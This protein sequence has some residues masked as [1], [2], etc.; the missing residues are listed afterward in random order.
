MEEATRPEAL[1]VGLGNPGRQYEGTRHN[2]G[3]AAVRELAARSS[4]D[5]RR[6][7][8]RSLT[9]RAMLGRSMVLL[10]EPQTFM[11]ASG[12]AAASALSDLGLPP[13]KVVAIYDD[14]DLPLGQL[15]VRSEGSPGGHRGVASLVQELGTMAFPRVRIGIGRPAAGSTVLEHVLSPFTPE[16]LPVLAEMVAR[17]ADAVECLV[18]DGVVAAMNRFNGR[19]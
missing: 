6:P 3:F 18:H 7:E 14:L 10:M 9:A 4:V 16:E 5:I 12:L 17:A 19:A 8:Y 11:N 15:R 1:V 13:A 2:V